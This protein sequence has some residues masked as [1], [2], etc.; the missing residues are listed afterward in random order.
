[1]DAITF[2]FL[3]SLVVSKELDMR[4]MGVITTY[5]YGSI[6][7]DIYIKIPE[8]FTLLEVV[9]EKPR[10]MCSIKLQRSMY[11]LKKSER[12]WYNRLSE[13]L[14]KEGYANNPICPCI[15]IKKSKTGFAIIAIYVDD[16]NLFG[17]PEELTRT[18]NYLKREFDM[19][20][21]G[22]FFFS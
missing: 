16:L 18:E 6:D 12:M 19:K 4:L 8:G 14:L 3:I 15:F 2:H 9:N 5:L 20:D 7:N 11:R 17:T 21:L 10:S 13:Y 1:M 22:N